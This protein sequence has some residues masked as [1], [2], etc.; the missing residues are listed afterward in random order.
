M[1][2]RLRRDVSRWA[3]KTFYTIDQRKLRE[4]FERIG[5][6]KGMTV[7][8]HSAMSRLGHFEGGPATIIE[9]LT[10]TVTESGCVV[11]PAYSTIG[12]VEKYIDQGNIF[13]VRTT[14]SAAGALTEVFRTWPG[15]KRSLHPTNSMTAWGR[16]AQWLLDGHELSLTPYGDETPFGRMARM[17]DS[18]NLLL[19][20][21][22]LSLLHH[23]QERVEFPNYTLDAQRELVVIDHDGKRRT[24]RTKVMRR[25]LPY[26]IAIPPEGDGDHDWAILHDFALM[27]PKWREAEAMKLYRLRGYPPIL[28]R[29]ARLTEA[30]IL[31]STRLGKGEIGMVRMEPFLDVLIPELSELLAR[32]R[33]CYELARLEAENLPLY[34]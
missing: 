26:Y 8:V 32:F 21:S 31:T 23:L 9:A 29:R 18:Y 13:D 16:H 28:S 15:V 6:G 33:S 34:T 17:K 10:E 14:P 25:R 24:V 2:Y 5:L 22:V 12:S 7:C 11:M 27:F 30:G 3:S 19:E 1:F 20:T 4:A